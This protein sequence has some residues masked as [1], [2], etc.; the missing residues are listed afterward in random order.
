M[1]GS[2]DNFDQKLNTSLSG[3]EKP[4]LAQH[5]FIKSLQL[6]P[7]VRHT[8]GMLTLSLVLLTPRVHVYK[9]LTFSRMHQPGPTLV[10][11]T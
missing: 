4:A 3:V 7:S 8:F 11:Y 9:G 6:E 2:L 5:A 1:V 10:S